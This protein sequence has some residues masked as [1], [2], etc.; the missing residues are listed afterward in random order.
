MSNWS[1][2]RC[3]IK[4][5]GVSQIGPGVGV[6]VIVSVAVANM[7]GDAIKVCVAVLCGMAV[8]I[9][10]GTRAA[11]DSTNTA[12]LVGVG[13]G[14]MGLV[15]ACKNKPAT[16]EKT[17]KENKVLIAA[18]FKMVR[19]CCYATPGTRPRPRRTLIPPFKVMNDASSPSPV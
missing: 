17:Q 8:G 14:L 7:V 2:L 19:L 12:E 11:V 3:S 9:C 10:V 4:L 15:Q 13:T 5:A 18:L 1:F 6:T 16:R